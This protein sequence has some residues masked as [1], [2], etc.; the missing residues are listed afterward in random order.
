MHVL[1]SFDIS[2][3]D[4]S[5]LSKMLLV[6]F[7]TIANIRFLPVGIGLTHNTDAVITVFPVPCSKYYTTSIT[8][9]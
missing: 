1:K 9:H 6:K 4:L 2:S 7:L 5:S 8:M 3:F